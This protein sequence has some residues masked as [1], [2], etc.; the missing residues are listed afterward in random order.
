MKICHVCKYECDDEAELCP[1]C[2]A[3]LTVAQEAGPEAETEMILENPVLLATF[4]DVVSAEI[5]KDMLKENAIPFSCDGEDGAVMKVTF[6][7]SFIAE[8]LYVDESNYNR[9]AELYEEFQN[10]EPVFEEAF[11]E[12]EETES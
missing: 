5:F 7:G 10:A 9:A 3:E 8:D 1:V 6:G 12:D 2:G 4:E 11:F